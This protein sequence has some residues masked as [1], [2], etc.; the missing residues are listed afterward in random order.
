MDEL[1]DIKKKSLKKKMRSALGPST[2]RCPQTVHLEWASWPGTGSIQLPLWCPAEP[3]VASEGHSRAGPGGPE[4]WGTQWTTL[5]LV[6]TLA[7][8]D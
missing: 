1:G 3:P 2:Q 6:S 5:C 4:R 7:G 8:P